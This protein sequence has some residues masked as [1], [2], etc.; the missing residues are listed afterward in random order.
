MSFNLDKYFIM[1]TINCK[2]NNPLLTLEAALQFG[3]TIFQLREKGEGALTGDAY[4]DFAKDCQQ[5]CKQ[6]KVPFIVNDDVAL[7]LAIDAE[8]IHV[9]Q[10]DLHLSRFRE[11]CPDKI[12]GV[13]VHTLAQLEQAIADGADYVGIGPVFETK[14]KADALQSSLAFLTDAK[15][16][17]PDFPIVAIGGITTKNSHFVRQ[18]GVDGVAVISEIT[19]SENIQQTLN[20][21]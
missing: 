4:V 1:G 7:A 21:L 3:V 17:Y 9:G 12:V 14:S 11:Q 5:L 8:G 13:S 19:E 10:D 18:L 6:Y 20:N 15:L 16:A 2:G